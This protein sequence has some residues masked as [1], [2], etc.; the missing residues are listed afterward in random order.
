MNESEIC[1]ALL[2]AR[3]LVYHWQIYAMWPGLTPGQ[4]KILK[5]KE[6]AARQRRR[7]LCQQLREMIRRKC[8]PA[9]L[10]LPL[11]MTR[12]FRR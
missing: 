6:R 7:A 9:Q 10:S 1:K 11:P 3:D 2:A 4:V 12:E 5:R 8:P